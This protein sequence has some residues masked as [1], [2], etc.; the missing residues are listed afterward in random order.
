MA[1][2]IDVDESVTDLEV[3]AAALLYWLGYS[4]VVSPVFIDRLLAAQ[5]HAT[6]FRGGKP[7]TVVEPRSQAGPLMHLGS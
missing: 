1:A 2:L 3:E 6:F 4:G 7:A 5:G